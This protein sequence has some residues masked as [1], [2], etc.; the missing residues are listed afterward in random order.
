MGFDSV[1]DVVIG[2]FRTDLSQGQSQ[3]L[4]CYDTYD[5][6][7][8]N[9]KNLMNILGIAN[10]IC[11]LQMAATH[12]SATGKNSVT[13]EWIPPIDFDGVVVFK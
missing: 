12:R 5:V 2:T 10:S 11:R 3:P 6:S 4:R 8:K 13:I 7:T 9:F 1:T